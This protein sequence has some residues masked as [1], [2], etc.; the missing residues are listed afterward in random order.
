MK[1]LVT[2][3]AGFI[4]SH[5]AERLLELNHEV[6]GVDSFTDYYSIKQKETNI[7][8]LMNEKRFYMVE[9]DLLKIDLP[10]LLSGV[11]YV[12]HQAAQAGVRYSWGDSF[13]VYTKNNI[14][15]TQKLLEACK[16]S[17]IKKLIYASS[18]SIYGDVK[19]LPM[20]ESATPA[21]VSPYG[22]TKLAAEH[23]CYL[24]SKNFKVPTISLRYFTVYGPRQRPDMAFNKF[25]KAIS[26]GEE[27]QVFGDGKQ[28][29][30]F[31]YIS[32]ITDA[33]ILAMQSDVD[34]GEAFNIG[35]G[36]RRILNDVIKIIEK[37]TGKKANIN[38]IEKQAGDV[39]HTY[40]DTSK[41]AD[42]LSYKPKI[43]LKQ[44]IKEEV[45]WMTTG[46]GLD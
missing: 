5:L 7:T 16:N 31:T 39:N 22:V 42:K 30:D 19:S 27:I 20:K 29:R 13:E 41:A 17:Q 14:L 26:S 36:S 3:C 28:T 33:N 9:K 34:D 10:K 44:G 4:G 32:D 38:Y 35:G 18:S 12:F 24:Y 21:P 2:G 43:S 37:E 15:S 46:T 40:A 23:L 45:K 25:I 11:D 1:T 8:D 6:I